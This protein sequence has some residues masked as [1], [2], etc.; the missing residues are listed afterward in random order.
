[1]KCRV[2]G[3]EIEDG[4]EFCRFCG[5]SQK[6]K[7]KPTWSE[8]K[9]ERERETAEIIK[10][11]HLTE[12]DVLLAV[13]VGT[14]G[15]QI[16]ALGETHK[17]FLK[18]SLLAALYLVV[19]A[20]A[21]AGLV[22]MIRLPMDGISRTLKAVISFALLLVLA[23]FGASF[24]DRFYSARVFS[25]M[26]KSERAVKKVSYGKAP[27]IT[28]SGKLYQLICNAKCPACG[29]EVHIEE[30][31]GKLY[32]VC[33]YDRTHLGVLSAHEIYRNLLGVEVPEEQK[34]SETVKTE[35][36]A[37]EKTCSAEEP[38]VL[39]DKEQ[40]KKDEDGSGAEQS[41]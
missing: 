1:M 8:R 17:Q 37:D 28:E 16:R 35:E 2:C 3:K 27:Y 38:S 36:K 21:L 20:A 40:S 29:G 24:A 31:D 41:R 5:A 4:S 30:F 33:N 14:E 18:C 34:A 13:P 6:K 19:T 32:T 26:D 25:K 9:K 12:Q 10:K 7:R 15:L 11:S 39:A 23:G 22:L